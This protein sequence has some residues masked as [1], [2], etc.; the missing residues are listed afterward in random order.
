MMIDPVLRELFRL[1]GIEPV[2]LS[3]MDPV[4]VAEALAEGIRQQ[5]RED[6]EEELGKEHAERRRVLVSRRRRRGP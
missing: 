5:V 3:Y 1:A 6:I 2:R 4:S